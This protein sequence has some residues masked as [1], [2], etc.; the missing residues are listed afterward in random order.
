MTT[1]RLKIFTGNA[2]RPLAEEICA[3]L[4]VPLGQS[5]VKRF[6]DEE[7][8]LQILENVR[9]ADV[10]VIQPTS[11]P[12]DRNLMELL[13]LIDALKRAS[14]ERITAGIPYYGY[15]RPDQKGKPRVP[16]SSQLVAELLTTAGANPALTMDLHTPQIPG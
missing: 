4:N 12:G 7:V 6:A 10:F 13:L 2:N 14:A 1:D 9:G 5:L 15:G 11:K 3:Q 16:I 8:Y